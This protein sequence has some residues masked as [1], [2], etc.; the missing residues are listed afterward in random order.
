[1]DDVSQTYQLLMAGLWSYGP[2]V[3]SALA[4]FFVGRWLANKLSHLV[5][6]VMDKNQGDPMLKGFL[7]NIT[8]YTLMVLVTITALGQL[9]VPTTSFL[10]ILGTAGLAIGLALKD[11]LSN[12]AAG[13]M[14]L[15]ARPFRIG[16]LIQVAGEKGKVM[17]MNIFETI[18]HTGDN[19]KIILSNSSV[20]GGTITNLTANGT[21]R[22]DLEVGIGY[23]DDIPQAKA[24]L[25]EI[26]QN[27]PLILKSPDHTVAVCALEDNSV[28]LVVRGWC[29]TE[30]YWQAKWS[31]LEEI[32]MTFDQ[33][34]ISFP[35]PQRDLHIVDQGKA[36]SMAMSNQ[37]RQG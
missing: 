20:M 8:Y 12:F 34:G 25:E 29:Q 13:V 3:L 32:K 1:M 9:G 33:R 7:T 6:T 14:L 21:R 2:M 28:N 4:T 24:A 26:L 31:L 5:G 23:D 22:I 17:R 19:Q 27:N 35:F 15:I 30:D 16:D 18:L 37:E 36:L 11:H 10:A